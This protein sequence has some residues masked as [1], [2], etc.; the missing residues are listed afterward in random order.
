MRRP[1]APDS[2]L[3]KMHLPLLV[4]AVDYIVAPAISGIKRARADRV[5]GE[6]SGALTRRILRNTAVPIALGVAMVGGCFALE[7]AGI[8]Q[9][10]VMQ[11]AWLNHHDLIQLGGGAVHGLALGAIEAFKP[12]AVG[13]EKTEGPKGRRAMKAG[14]RHARNNFLGDAAQMAV[15]KS[16]GIGLPAST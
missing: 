2:R 1:I 6:P 12:E 16:L 11:R 3:Q 4:D 8:G 15:F 14:L 5:P 7:R 13:L 10:P 9:S